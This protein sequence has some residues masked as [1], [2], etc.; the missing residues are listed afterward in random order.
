M[1]SEY[2]L[3]NSITLH[4]TTKPGITCMDINIERDDL[5]VTGGND[6]GVIFYNKAQDKVNFFT[7]DL[8]H[9][10]Q[11]LLTHT[12]NTTKRSQ[13]LNLFQSQAGKRITFSVF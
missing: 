9:N 2:K 13:M 5:I 7:W 1:I 11:R 6:G 3:T 12:Q 8:S 4:S 10:F